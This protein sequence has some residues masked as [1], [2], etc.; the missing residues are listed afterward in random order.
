MNHHLIETTHQTNYYTCATITRT[1]EKDAQIVAFILKKF[2]V[3]DH[4][5]C[6]CITKRGSKLTEISYLKFKNVILVMILYSKDD[7]FESENSIYYI[8]YMTYKWE[9]DGSSSYS[10]YKQKFQEG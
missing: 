5:N 7:S 1:S 4:L 9:H 8:I 10:M 6:W 2:S 3:L